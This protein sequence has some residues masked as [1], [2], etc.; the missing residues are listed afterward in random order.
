MENFHFVSYQFQ[1]IPMNIIGQAYINRSS[2][3]IRKQLFVWNTLKR[4]KKMAFY[5]LVSKESP[6]LRNLEPY[7]EHVVYYKTVE[8]FQLVQQADVICHS[9][10]SEYALPFI[11]DKTSAF[12]QTKN[13][14]FLRHGII[15][16]KYVKSLYQNDTDKKVADK[17]IVS[18]DREKDIIVN[19]YGFKDDE[20]ITTGLARFDRVIKERRKWIKKFKNRNRFL[21]MP[22][23]RRSLNI[24]SED[25]FMETD[26]YKA[27][28]S[29]IT[30]P[31]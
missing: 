25:Q 13:R 15:G 27:Y 29:L 6:D 24:L 30:D 14:I 28:Q 26:Y 5:F 17:L 23:W 4:H 9:H 2:R 11:S 3:T 16:S 1:K 19:E 22:T 7:K 21:I 20:V 8:N 12:I 10:M 31:A 18:S